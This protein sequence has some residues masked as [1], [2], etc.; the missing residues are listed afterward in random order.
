M[1]R[2]RQKLCG[3][4][5]WNIHLLS[6]LLRLFVSTS[7]SGYVFAVFVGAN[8][9]STQI[10]SSIKS[11]VSFSLINISCLLVM[12][13]LCC[14]KKTVLNCDTTWSYDELWRRSRIVGNYL[15]GK[16]NTSRNII[17]YRYLSDF[18]SNQ[19]STKNCFIANSKALIQKFLVKTIVN[20]YDRHNKL[21]FL[22]ISNEKQNFNF[23]I[24]LQ[25]TKLS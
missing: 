2:N 1:D 16:T 5:L 25:Q 21:N 17:I 22:Q 12:F 7:R 19:M 9:S 4:C 8:V 3:N 6:D 15:P 11:F 23:S 13:R 18:S 24:R 20:F 14:L 10:F